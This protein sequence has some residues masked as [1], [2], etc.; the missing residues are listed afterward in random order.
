MSDARKFRFVSPGIFLNEV[1]RSQIP[2]A[3]ENVG[4]VIIGRAE[5]GPGMIP[6]RVNSFSE[7][8][9]TFGNPIDGKGGVDDLWRETNKSSPTYG[10]YAAQAYLAA[11]V[12]P[13]T[14]VRLVGT[15]HDDATAA[16]QA[17]WKTTATPTV[18][19]S[20]T[21]GAYG[22]FV[23]PSSSLGDA[24]EAARAAESHSAA[25]GAVFYMN[26]GIPV[27]S[28]TT[29]DGIQGRGAATVVASDTAGN[30][31]VE[32]LN[33]TLGTTREAT[34]NFTEGSTNFIRNQFNT[35]PQLVGA[36]ESS[37]VST[38]YWLG[39]T[40]ERHVAET[41]TTNGKL[42][43]CILAIATGSTFIGPSDRE[44]AYRDSHSG[45]FFSQNLSAD[46]T[47]YKYSN[48]TKLFK[49]VGI[50]G[51]GEWIQ[52]N[53]KISIANIKASTNDNSPYG[54]FDVLLRKASDSD[55]KPVIL[56]RY[57]NCTLDP[58]SM[59]YIAVKIGD[60]YQDWDDAEKR[61]REFG[62]YPNK[63]RYLRVVVNETLEAGGLSPELLPFGV[64]GPPRFNTFN[65]N[66]GS[67]VVQVEGQRGTPAGSAASHVAA[68]GIY[69]RG[70]GSMAVVQGA[71]QDR[72]TLSTRFVYSGAD[73]T[74]AGPSGEF[75]QVTAS[76]PAIGIRSTAGQDASTATTNTYFGLHSGKSSTV[77]TPD[78]GYPDYLRCL[79]ADVISNAAWADTFGLSG[80]GELDEQWIFTLDEIIPTT[81]SAFSSSAPTQN[82]TNATWTSGSMTHVNSWNAIN[83]VGK[84]AARYKNIL[85]SKINRFTSPLFGGFDG[86]DIT[87]RDPF[88]NT[89]LDAGTETTNYA[90]YTIQR[91]IDTVSDPEVLSC[92]IMTVPGVTNES[93]TKYLIDTAEGRAD[94]LGVIDVKG[95]FQPRH[96]RDANIATRRGDLNAVLNNMRDRNLNNSY[97][98]AY[99]PWVTIRDDINQSFVKAPPSV[100]ALG[101]L[102]NTEKAADVW[103]APAGF[104]RGG[105]S[106][107]A[108]GVPVLSVETK[109]TSR[110]RDDL[111][112]I[113]I[114]P[115]A[116]FPSEGLVVFGQ[117]TLQ[118]T[119]SAL[120][121]INV[122]RLLIYT[123]KGISQI[124]STTLFQPNVRDTW[125]GFKTRAENFLSDVKVRFG[126]DDFKVLLDETTTTP[127]LVD[128]NIM[129]A[130][131]FIKPTRAIEFIAID[132]VITRSGA[133]FED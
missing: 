117:K 75:G 20:T 17:G 16:G 86:L 10:G 98:C 79:G 48:M 15:Q 114:N 130:K 2:A 121:R 95:G 60:T 71:T 27:L 84:G 6:V 61:Y 40:F 106:Q 100:V 96:E 65:F 103:F 94:A 25:L 9:E 35:N 69:V 53:I 97:G 64:Y 127:D 113:N 8:V 99:Y 45:W 4:P 77:T 68:S 56:E 67:T 88:R 76:F 12:G 102:A 70:S 101:V 38:H 58:K 39:E 131:I 92:N 3:P 26:S 18:E 81:G 108:G 24:T 63:S 62:N 82:I 41:V 78:P 83:S 90:Y 129:Y 52:N 123:K 133:S 116:S 91:A 104:Q 80:Y 33:S 23:F 7:F 119:Q 109:L 89:L 34:C 118:S 14:Y 19:I 132:F 1:D 110:N 5:K 42:H 128:R 125:N 126:V 105:L 122:R 57:S 51:H 66:S 30:F 111:Y 112:D 13:I 21:G 49:F 55:L 32:V 85:D 28:G 22:L 120:D 74:A 31:R 73:N 59:D 37:D 72:T 43:G 29:V 115:I 44:T 46:T 54:T 87:E 11:G 107:G 93:L 47:T 36:I 50:N 124:A